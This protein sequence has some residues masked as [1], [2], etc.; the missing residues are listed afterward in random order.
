MI[1]V[2]HFLKD[3]GIKLLFTNKYKKEKKLI[4]IIGIN[5]YGIYYM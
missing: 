2:L 5:K 4:I 1:H 3:K